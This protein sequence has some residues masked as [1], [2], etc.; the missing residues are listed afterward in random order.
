MMFCSLFLSSRDLLLLWEE[1][2]LVEKRLDV[3]ISES[4]ILLDAQNLAHGS[5]GVNGVTL[6]GILQL[7]GIHVRAE[8]TSNISGGH[9]RA[10]GL[11]EEVAEFILEGDRGGEDGGALL[12]DNAVLTLLLGATT[13]TTSLLDL[14]GNT[15]LETLESLDGAD[16]LITKSLVKGHKG[17]NLLL[18]RLDLNSDRVHDGGGD[19]G[20]RGSRSNGGLGLLGGWGSSSGNWG[21]WSGC[22]RSRDGVRLLGNFL[23]VLGCGAG[24]GGWLAH[25]INTGGSI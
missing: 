2:E 3:A 11:A 22:W 9:L 24:G 15:L 19:R 6:L 18:D 4:L 13:T 10:L 8:G 1:V 25:C 20:S 23:H 16:R 17:G 21:G 5:V 12:L 14:L 7:V